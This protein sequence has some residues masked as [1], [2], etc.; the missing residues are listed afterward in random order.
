MK[1]NYFTGIAAIGLMLATNIVNGQYAS[2]DVPSK[3]IASSVRSF[4]MSNIEKNDFSRKAAEDLAKSFKNVSGETWIKSPGGY[5]VRFIVNDI[6]HLVFYDKRGNRLYTIRNYD[7]TKM[8]G[9]IRHMVK[10]TY[11]DYNIRLVQEIENNLNNIAYIVHLEG[12]TQWINVRVHD[13]EM[14]EFEKNNKSE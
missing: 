5:Y 14:D 3:R 2:N 8:P 9:D 7:E 12:K 1:R 13:G 10:S 4:S 11:Y 6:D